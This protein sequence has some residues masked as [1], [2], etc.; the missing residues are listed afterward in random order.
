MQPLDSATF[1]IVPILL[2]SVH[3]TM[4]SLDLMSLATTHPPQPASPS[5]VSMYNA[6]TG[7]R[8]SQFSLHLQHP[9]QFLV[10]CSGSIDTHQTDSYSTNHV[11]SSSAPGTMEKVV[12][13]E[14]V[15]PLPA[16]T[17]DSVN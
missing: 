4:V 14:A 15:P 10:R 2:P 5:S 12:R 9:E 6:F 3:F 11:C 16:K 13:A 1:V 7:Q 8:A 17:S